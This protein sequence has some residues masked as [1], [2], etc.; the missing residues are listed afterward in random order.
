MPIGYHILLVELSANRGTS[1]VCGSVITHSWQIRFML[2]LMMGMS[3]DHCSTNRSGSYEE[4]GR[5][6]AIAGVGETINRLRSK[7]PVMTEPR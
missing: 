3:L 1:L 2:R 4:A 6:T 5:E 7:W